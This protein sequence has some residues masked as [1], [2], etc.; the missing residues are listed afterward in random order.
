MTAHRCAMPGCHQDATG[1]FCSSCYFR[2]PAK[3]AKWLVR[4]QIMIAR[5]DDTELKDHLREQL[6]GYTQAAIRTLRN[7]EARSSQAASDGARR[8][9]S[10]RAAGAILMFGTSRP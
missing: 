5:S 2:L 6:H 1:I 4:L 7:A 3:D 10:S 8:Q 9:S